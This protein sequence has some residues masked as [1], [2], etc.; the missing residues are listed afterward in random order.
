MTTRQ[1][2]EGKIIARAWEDEEF[3]TKLESNP[4]EAIE[5]VLGAALPEGMTVNIAQESE[6]NMTIVLPPRPT[7]GGSGEINE[8]D[9][10]A[11]AGGGSFDIYSAVQ[12][13]SWRSSFTVATNLT[14]SSWTSI[15]H[16][17]QD[18]W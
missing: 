7:A 13:S 8:D 17:Y 3:R 1:E 9:L 10:E 4:K 6:T 14:K 18:H 11:V 16:G 2:L 12:P 5:E 15:Q